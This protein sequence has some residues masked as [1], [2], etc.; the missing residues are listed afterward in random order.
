MEGIVEKCTKD[1]TREDV[2]LFLYL[3]V[4]VKK[5]AGVRMLF[6]RIRLSHYKKG[7]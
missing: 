4:A 1:D 6:P 2:A 3:M 5:S 7:L